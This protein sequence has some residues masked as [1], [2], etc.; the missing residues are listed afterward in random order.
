MFVGLEICL[1]NPEISRRRTVAHLNCL[2]QSQSEYIYIHIN[3]KCCEIVAETKTQS[4][5]ESHYCATSLTKLSVVLANIKVVNLL[6]G[7]CL[8]T[9]FSNT[10][11]LTPFQVNMVHAVVILYAAIYII[12]S[13]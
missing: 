7:M 10:L 5:H 8:F 1:T 6:H 13:A 12:L 4:A 3:V 2:K 9:F 11:C